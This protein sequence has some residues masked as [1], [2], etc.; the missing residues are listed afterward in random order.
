MRTITIVLSTGAALTFLQ[1]PQSTELTGL[2]SWLTGYAAMPADTFAAGPPSGAFLNDGRRAEPAFRAQPVQG[3]SSIWPD[4]DGW[5]W[6]L[7]DNGFGSKRN[8]PDYLLRIYR[9]RPVFEEKRVDVDEAFV[10]L[11]DP[12]RRVPFHIV[13]ENTTD[14]LLTGADFDPESMIRLGD[15]TFWIGDEFGPFLLHVAGDGRLLGPPVEAPGVRSPDNPLLAAAD[16]GQSSAATVRRSRGFEG[17]ALNAPDGSLFAL[18]EAGLVSDEGK[19][20]R[21]LE[22]NPQARAFTGRTWSIPLEQPGHSLTELVG[23]GT[24]S[25]PA[26]KSYR[27]LAIER[28]EGHGAEARFKKVY[29]LDMLDERLFHPSP[30]RLQTVVKHGRAPSPSALVDLLFIEDPDR[31]ATSGGRFTFP[32]ITTEAVWPLAEQAL[33]L[34]NDNNYPATGGRLEGQRDQTEFI[35]L[36]VQ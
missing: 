19:S 20:T 15:G 4:T 5:F 9:V 35:R 8:S 2:T 26:D 22:F 13:N 7:S 23:V 30:G 32:Y 16:A 33:L 17:L 3:F 10:Q 18:L 21:L 25:E 29:Y 36:R 34:V 28:D 6:A 14:R 24:I 31:L 12:D 11:R 1:I 27:F